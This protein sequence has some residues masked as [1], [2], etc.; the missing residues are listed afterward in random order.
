MTAKFQ[1]VPHRQVALEDCF[2]APRQE[3]NRAVTLPIEYRHL[4][5]TG[6]IDALRLDWKTGEPNPPH[7]FWESD[8]AKWI[9]AAAYSLA[10]HPDPDLEQ[11]VDEVVDL[12]EAAQQP[13]GYLNAHFTVVEPDKR[14]T[15]LRDWHELY[16]AGHLME[17]AVALFEATGKRTLLE[18]MCR[19]ADYIAQVFGPEEDRKK[20]Y[21]GHEE[22][23]LALVRLAHAVGDRRYLEL[24]RFFVDQRGTMPNY[25]E[26]EAKARGEDPAATRA[27]LHYWQAHCPVRQQTTAEGHAVR[28][29]YLYSGMT[30]LAGEFDDSALLAA[31]KT[32]FG[33]VTGRRMYVTGGIGSTAAGEAFTHDYDLPNEAA[34]AETCAAIGLVF[35]CARMLQAECNARYADVMERALYNGVL[36]GVSLDG[37]RFFYVNPLAVHRTAEQLQETANDSERFYGVRREWFGCACCPPNIARVIA[38]VGRYFYSVGNGEIAVHLYADGRAQIELRG[39]RISLCQETRYPWDGTVCL[40]ITPETATRFGLRLRVPQWCPSAVFRINGEAVTPE[41]VLGYARFE[42]EWRP[43]DVI[44]CTLS[45]P[46]QRIY[47]HPRVRDDRGRVAFQRGPI[48]YCFEGVD[49]RN[50]LDAVAIPRDAVFEPHWAPDLLGGVVVLRGEGARFQTTMGD[51]PAYTSAPPAAQP[52]VLRAVPYC[53]WENRER[54]DMLVWMREKD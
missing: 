49:N 15:N 5:E 16:C 39:Q 32:L 21:P 4:K 9:E 46:V 47:A 54:G 6:R 14:W 7:I 31:C 22:I 41:I 2:W 23:E 25:F 12:F 26:M 27:R 35:W 29:M 3:T 44:E 11:H 19:Y 45:M 10:V 38:A 48:V 24:S 43:G 37:R 28:A 1:P 52:V 34:Y 8:V 40:T 51:S 33:N 42:R 50:M 18:V 30:D 13:D 17:A 36:S 53:T 20:G